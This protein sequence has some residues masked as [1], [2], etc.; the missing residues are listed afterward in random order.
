MLLFYDSTLK[1]API[2][3]NVWL[4]TLDA[5]ILSTLDYRKTAPI[6]VHI[7]LFHLEICAIF[8]KSICNE[9]DNDKAMGTGAVDIMEAIDCGNLC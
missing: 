6:C 7:L 3:M 9:N 1:S 8:C 4:G 5:N 2:S